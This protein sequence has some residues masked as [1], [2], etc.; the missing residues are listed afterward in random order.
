[1]Q[2]NDFCKLLIYK[3]IGMFADVRSELLHANFRFSK[4]PYKT[5]I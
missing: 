4:T 3:G 2:T 5:T 1:M